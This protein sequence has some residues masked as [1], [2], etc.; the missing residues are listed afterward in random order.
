MQVVLLT[1]V[2]NHCDGQKDCDGC[3]DNGGHGD[4]PLYAGFDGKVG[5][6]DCEGH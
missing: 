2:Q 1:Y 4:S 3:E 5:G 6:S